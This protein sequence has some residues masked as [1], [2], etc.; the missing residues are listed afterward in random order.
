MVFDFY[1]CVFFHCVFLFVLAVMYKS[2]FAIHW[3]KQTDMI[4]HTQKH[5]YKQ[6]MQNENGE[7][8]RA[9]AC[10][11]HILIFACTCNV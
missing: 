10:V 5:K 11:I 2:L 7:Q 4:D 9:M 6:D 1:V 8:N 3:Q